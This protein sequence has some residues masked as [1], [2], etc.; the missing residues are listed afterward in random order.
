MTENNIDFKG[1]KEKSIKFLQENNIRV[2]NEIEIIKNN[3]KFRGI[4]LPRNKFAKDGFIE[5]KLKNGYNIGIE[6]DDHTRAKFIKERKPM[7]VEFEGLTIP[8]DKRKAKVS[9]I[10]TGGT[11]A[12]RLDY[13]TGG[14]IPAF[15]PH[16]LYA[17]VPELSEIANIDTHI[18]LQIFSEDMHPK[19]WL[20]MAEKVAEL[21]NK[22]IDGIVIA[23]GTDT[24]GYSASALSFLLK[25]LKCPVVFV[26]SQRS[27]DRP[28]SDAALNLINAV[29]VAAKA[30]LAEVVL[31]MLGSS[32]HTYGLIHRG[33]LVRKMH[34][35]VRHTFRTIGDI[36]LGKIENDKIFFFKKDYKRKSILPK[37]V[38][39]TYY[40]NI[41]EKVALIYVHPGITPELIEFYIDKGYKGIVL[42]GTG[43][44]HCPHTLFPALKRAN[45]EGI[46]TVMTVQTLW[47]FTGMDVYETG[48]EEQAIGIIPGANML[49]ETAFTKLAWALGNF[50]D[51]NRVKQI[52]QT[53]IAGE[54]LTKEAYNGYLVFQGIEEPH[55]KNK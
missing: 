14:V 50:D 1:Y 37:D 33:T 41:E 44:G 23:H 11:I 10:G 19:Y 54:I 7:V 17:A 53:N 2:W 36:P 30:D 16:E 40:K 8:K 3:S 4:L 5:I 12:S 49:P 28:S 52:M 51:I 35:S 38:T 43:L 32:S 24:M 39:T 42:A 31:C 48:R 55:F 27:S 21:S 45:D 34:S 13:T 18:V 22:D 9:L 46:V 25:D 20:K 15:K 47:G 29:N 6:I 26:G